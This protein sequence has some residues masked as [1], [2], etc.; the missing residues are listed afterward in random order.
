VSNVANLSDAAAN[1]EANALA[2]LMNGGTLNLYSGP[3]PVNAN[4]AL[5]GNTLLA[6]LGFGSPAFGAA[7]GGVI[8]ANPIA[9]G[10]AVATGTATFARVLEADGETVV[11]DLAVGVANAAIIL[12]STAIVAGST[13]TVSAF[14]YSV[15]ET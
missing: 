7:S 9:G 3:Q 1:V 5:A 8:D 14:A 2:A 12:N 4:T 15:Q 11:M 6:S 13:V 10:V